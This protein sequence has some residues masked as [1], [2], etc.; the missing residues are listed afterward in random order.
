M[1]LLLL[2]CLYLRK[3]FRLFVGAFR[4]LSYSALNDAHWEKQLEVDE[5]LQSESVTRQGCRVS[6]VPR[7]GLKRLSGCKRLSTV[8]F[9]YVHHLKLIKKHLN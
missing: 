6:S 9:P 5:C 4:L 1:V 8:V 2:N 7:M 3:D